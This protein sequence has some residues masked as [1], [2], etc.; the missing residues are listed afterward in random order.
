MSES[1]TVCRRASDINV[2]RNACGV[3]DVSWNA[4]IRDEYCSLGKHLSCRR[5]LDQFRVISR[6]VDVDV[7]VP[8]G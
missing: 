8:S 1:L 3:S 4:L 5:Q 2:Q 6:F 7:D